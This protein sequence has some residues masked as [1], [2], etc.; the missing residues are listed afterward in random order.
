MVKYLW[1][2]MLCLPGSWLLTTAVEAASAGGSV[3]EAK[4]SAESRGFQFIASRDEIVAKAKQ[5]GSLRVISSMDTESFK[6]MM[7]T[8]TKKYPFIKVRMDEIGGPEALQR[9]LLELK[10]GAVKE[11]DTSEASS[12]FYVEN[13]AHAMKLDLLGMA[14]QGVLALN[15]KMVDPEYRNVVSVASSICGIAYNKNR[16]AAEAVPDKWEDFLKPEFKGRKFVSDIRTQCMATLVPLMGEEWVVRYARQLKDQQPVWLRGNARAMTAI[17]TGEQAIHQMTF[18]NSCMDAARKDVT[19]SLVC[20]IVEPA[21]VWLRENQF[22]LKN[23]PHPHAALL[24]I[25]HMA[26]SEGQKI[27][28]EYEPLKSSMYTDGEVS[29]LIKGKKVS[30]ND[31]RTFHNT[32]KWMKIIVDAYGFPRAEK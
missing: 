14:Q 1:I 6:P 21:P 16:M 31:H 18:Y 11:I 7:A 13:A 32:P 9:F 15:P 5:E 17:A 26:S 25:E 27:M 8:F 20:K 30:V 4:K 23:A 29:R 19:K 3:L 24:F 22:I 10:A 28:D 2:A 12:E